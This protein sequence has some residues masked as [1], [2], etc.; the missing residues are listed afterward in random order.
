MPWESKTVEKLRKEFIQ[1][2]IQKDVSLSALCREYGISRPTA[3]KWINRFKNGES[4]AD[5]PH[6][7]LFKPRKTPI[8]KEEL[9][10]YTRLEYPTWG[11]R[12]IRRFLSE[13]GYDELPAT[14]TIA[15]ILKRNGCISKEASEAHTP[16]KRFEK[17]NPND[18]WQM[19]YKGNFGL[20]NGVRCF[21]L[22]ILDDCSRFSLCINAK[23]NERWLPAKACLERVFEE[24]GLPKAILCDNGNPWGS[25]GKGYTMFDIWMM[26]MNVLPIHGR[27]LHPQT[28]GKDERF[29]RTLK[30]DL[31]KRTVLRDLE[32]AQEEFDKFR[33]CYN[34]ERPHESLGLDVPAKHYKISKTPYTGTEKDPE[35][36]SGKQLRKVNYKGY[37]SI[38]RHRY[39]LSESFIG[40]YLEIVPED[41]NLLGLCYGKFVIAKID[42][43]EKQIVS[44]RIYRR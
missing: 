38:D 6:E 34:Y 30:E 43:E 37:I 15:D 16:W 36:D 7:A 5:K 8:E 13:K 18:M 35:Y 19:D 21:P 24:Y 41:E 44:K 3:Y 22:T 17:D 26:Q 9:I 10:L 20:C 25:M 11:P 12:K 1:K 31:I 4:L 27:I 33:Y 39:F 29:H 32:H 40:K 28:Q 2:A 23:D 14:S 42:T